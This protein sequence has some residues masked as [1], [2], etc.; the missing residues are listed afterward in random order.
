MTSTN[1]I[2]AISL[3]SVL[4]WLLFSSP[5]TAL[6]PKLKTIQATII[7]VTDGDTVVVKIGTKK[8]RVRL[9]GIDTPE[10]HPN[11]RAYKQSAQSR[12]D[13]KTIVA[14]GLRA[15]DFTQSLLPPGTA[16]SLEYDVEPRDRYG[17][18]LAYLWLTDGRMVNDI[19]I[20]S[21]YAYPL[22]VPPNVRYR[23]RFSEAFSEGRRAQRG[24]WSTH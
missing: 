11:R 18:A 6:D 7:S 13:V 14:M 22:T 21:G 16:V 17:R 2:R 4:A 12:Q 3:L 1:S 10:S 9:I 5:V 19:I 15:S 8:E 23:D 20:R 24:L